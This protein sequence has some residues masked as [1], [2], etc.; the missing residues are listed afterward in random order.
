MLFSSC[1]SEPVGQWMRC[2]PGYSVSLS[3]RRQVNPAT[4]M[5]SEPVGCACLLRDIQVYD[6]TSLLGLTLPSPP[7]PSSPPLSPLSFPFLSP[8]LSPSLPHPLSLPNPLS[9]EG[10][11]CLEDCHHQHQPA[12][13][14]CHCSSVLKIVTSIYG[15]VC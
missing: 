4:P 5:T 6:C 7:S 14:Y 3:S 12:Q 10:S 13:R 2:V 15:Q 8:F 9:S 1:I 11:W